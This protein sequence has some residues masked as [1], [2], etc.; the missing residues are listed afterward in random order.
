MK[1]LKS[2]SARSLLS[3]FPHL[4]GRL[5]GGAFWAGGY[6]V[7]TVGS[8]VDASTVQQYILAHMQEAP[9]PQSP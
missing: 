2:L 3:E 4:R 5:Y 1:L 6:F 9:E 8:G 7:R